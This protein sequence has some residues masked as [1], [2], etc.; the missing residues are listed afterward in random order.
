M[1]FRSGG[2]GGIG[3]QT[4]PPVTDD[5]QEKPVSDP[6]LIYTD[7]PD[8]AWY[9]QA[10]G[11]VTD[12]KLMTGSD[13]AFEPEAPMTRAMLMTVLARLDGQDTSDGL[14]WYEKGVAWA[15]EKGISDGSQPND[16]I[17]REQLAAMLYRHAGSPAVTGNADFDDSADIS[18]YALNAV[19]WANEKGILLGYAD[20]KLLPGRNATRAEMAAI[21]MRYISLTEK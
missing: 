16:N 18:P 4:K 5:K 7:I 13:G 17:T 14:T 19:K 10:V 2:S 12:M 3:G 1:L 6:S 11:F 21:L 8:D 20:G 15:V 9:G